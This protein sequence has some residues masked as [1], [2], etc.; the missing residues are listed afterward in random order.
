MQVVWEVRKCA[1]LPA[2]LQ[3]GQQHPA[4][5]QPRRA[6]QLPPS[7]LRHEARRSQEGAGRERKLQAKKQL[8]KPRL[9]KPR[10]QQLL[11]PL[12]PQPP[13]PLPQPRPQQQPLQPQVRPAGAAKQE[14]E[15]GQR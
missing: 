15:G 9:K 3:P 11:P 7:P 10:W 13:P 14:G 8:Q 2:P 4:S 1:R 6:P 12:L 5:P